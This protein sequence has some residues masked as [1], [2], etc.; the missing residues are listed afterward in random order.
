[1][2]LMLNPKVF[3]RQFNDIY[4]VNKC[5][6]GDDFASFHKVKDQHHNGHGRYHARS[7]QGDG[8]DGRKPKFSHR[9]TV[10]FY[11]YH[12]IE[13]SYQSGP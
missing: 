7:Q 4:P 3:A 10:R 9:I 5:P 1:M 2:F 11:S 13:N 8:S 6:E 12:E